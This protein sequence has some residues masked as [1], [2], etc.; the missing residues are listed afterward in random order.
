MITATDGTP[1]QRMG[2]CTRTHIA[3]TFEAILEPCAISI[4]AC[5]RLKIVNSS[6]FWYGCMSITNIDNI[7]SGDLVAPDQLTVFGIAFF[8]AKTIPRWTWR[9]DLSI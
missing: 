6:Q 1:C 7:N 4:V 5:A 2:V 9:A 3:G 8:L